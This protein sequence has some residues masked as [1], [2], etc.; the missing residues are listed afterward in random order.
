MSEDKD[1]GHHHHHHHHH[2]LTRHQRRLLA[3]VAAFVIL[4][5]FVILLVYLILHPS[6]PRFVLQDATVYAFN[7]TSGG[8]LLTTNFQ[9]TLSAHNPN[10]RVGIYYDR[11]DVYAAY[12]GQ[13]ITLPTLLPPAYQ[14]R[15][16]SDVWS[17]FVYGTEVPVAPYLGAA[18]VEDQISR[19]LM[20]NVRVV[21]K[22]RWKVG[23]FISGEYRLYV[24]CPAYIDYGGAGGVKYQL[25]MDCHVDV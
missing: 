12:R 4:V 2:H 24:N 6:K 3:A 13:Q 8:T 17:P 1:C 23:T 22:V 18:L 11:L 5:L 20:I 15:G 14:G 25:I 7:L 21:G 9:V 19:N 10:D 16:D